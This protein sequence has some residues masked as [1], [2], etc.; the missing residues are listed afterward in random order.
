MKD[1]EKE[2]NY[3]LDKIRFEIEENGGGFLGMLQL[4]VKDFKNI[5]S[6]TG[7]IIKREK[8]QKQREE[9]LKKLGI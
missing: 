3:L 8:I 6:K 7:E 5:I 4:D 2:L 9:Q 1:S